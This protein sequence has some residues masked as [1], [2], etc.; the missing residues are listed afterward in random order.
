MNLTQQDRKWAEQTVEKIRAKMHTVAERCGDK[1]PYTTKD[2]VF[3]DRQRGH[4]LVDERLLGRDDVADVLPDKGR[5]V[6]DESGVAGEKAGRGS[7][8]RG[9]A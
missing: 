4:Q 3:D 9:G 6:P 5:D 8:E 1:V 7:D 2:G